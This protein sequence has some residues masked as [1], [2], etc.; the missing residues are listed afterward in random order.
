MMQ[1][2]DKVLNINTADFRCSQRLSAI[3]GFW[4]N[5]RT[6]Q[7]NAKRLAMLRSIPS[8]AR[9]AWQP[10]FFFSIAS[11]DLTVPPPFTKLYIES[12]ICRDGD[13]RM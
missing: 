5:C 9:L 6:L 2:K 13:S 3:A 10:N 11:V 8:Q 12:G 7:L 4:E 1:W